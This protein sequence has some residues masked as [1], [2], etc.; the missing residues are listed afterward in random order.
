MEHLFPAGRII[1][2]NFTSRIKGV[3]RPRDGKQLKSIFTN[4]NAIQQMFP[5]YRKH[6]VTFIKERSGI[7]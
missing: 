6:M 4:N 2:V 7:Q 1:S 5:N 3:Y